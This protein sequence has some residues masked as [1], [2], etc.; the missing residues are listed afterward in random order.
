[1]TPTEEK[2][3]FQAHL[4]RVLQEMQQ[5]QQGSQ[6]RQELIRRIEAIDASNPRRLLLYVAN[7]N[8]QASA[9]NPADIVPLGDALAP[10]QKV[11]NLD[12]M[13]HTFGGSGETAEKIVEMCRNHC[14]G[15][16]DQ[17][18]FCASCQKKGNTTHC[19]STQKTSAHSRQ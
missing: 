17:M 4:T 9:V 13:I 8:H 7:T 6:N 15:E 11:K 18:V 3:K 14:E 12:L 19:C 2:R 16:L 5:V 1:M 10:I